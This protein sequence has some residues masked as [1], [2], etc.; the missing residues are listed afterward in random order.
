MLTRRCLVW[1]TQITDK[2]L[3]MLNAQLNP[4]TSDSPEVPSESRSYTVEG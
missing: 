2:E 3:T 4:P 1:I